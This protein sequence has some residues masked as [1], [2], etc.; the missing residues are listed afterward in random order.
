MLIGDDYLSSGCI[1]G[2]MD[3]SMNSKLTTM[4][5]WPIPPLLARIIK[6]NAIMEINCISL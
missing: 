6:L 1:C 4:S 3:C 5:D 2:E